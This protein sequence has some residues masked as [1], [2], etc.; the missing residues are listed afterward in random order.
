MLQQL[1]LQA[2]GQT[3]QLE[4]LWADVGPRSAWRGGDGEDWERG[5]YYVDG[6]LPLAHLLQDEQLLAKAADWV[7][8]ILASQRSDGQFGPE[9]NDDWWPRMV[10]LKV[11]TQHADATSDVRVEPFL[12]HYFRFQLAHLPQRPL[13]GW[14]RARGADNALS[15]LW[16][17]ERTGGD[18]LLQLAE[19][20][21]RQTFHWAT[22][23]TH[24]LPSRPVT[25]FSH[26]THGVN[27]AMGLKA[28]AAAYL[29]DGGDH[30]A[31]EVRAMFASLEEQ[32]GLVHG[33]F[34]GDEWLGGREPHHGVETCQ[35]VELM[36]TLEQLARVFGSGS[37]GDRLEQ[38]AFNLL[39]AAN[40]ASM[41]SHQYHQQANQVLV[42]VAQRDWTFSGDDANIFGHEPHYGCCT[43]N[44]HQ[45][46]PKLARS[47]WMQDTQDALTVVAYAPCTVDAVVDGH[48][49]SL[50]IDTDYPFDE[51]V[52]VVVDPGTAPELTLRL[53]VPEWCEATRLE[54]AGEP[55]DCP[56]PVDGYITIRRSWRPGDEV[57]LT[58]PMTL[59][60]VPRDRG[61]V[62]LRLGPLVMALAVGEVWRPLP[63]SSGLGDWEVTPRTWWNL[64]LWLGS[65]GGPPAWQVERRRPSDRPF[66]GTAAPVIVHAAGVPLKEWTMTGHSA[67]PPPNSPVESTL[68]VQPVKL[69]PYGCARLR[70]SE[71]P[72]AVPTAKE[73]M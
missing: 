10:A 67:G 44:L 69:L 6:L 25:S 4:E 37:F 7:N 22:F 42:S 70:V 19:L 52:R 56:R 40:D 73:W 64:G 29:V 49:V 9:P 8:A 51:L 11:L 59:R 31:G 71:L 33:T 23:L 2:D 61:A 38:V 14:A 47:L 46:W 13:A 53:R 27:V 34:S 32:H 21:L 26:R 35:V 30:H 18:W 43:A 3:G 24:E 15:V 68:P 41:T 63:G 57:V 66:S 58:L 50:L 60:T 55:W 36:F 28:P 5:P 65:P 39:A 45:G 1:R 62:G 72:V 48:A 16:F 17:H 12:E 54:V 20:L